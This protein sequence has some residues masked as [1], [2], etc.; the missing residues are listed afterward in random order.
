MERVD[1]EHVR[2]VVYDLSKD[3]DFFREQQ[4][5][6]A[7]T[8]AKV[9]V[10]KSHMAQLTP[11]QV[12]VAER[13]VAA[14]IAKLESGRAL[15]RIWLVVDMDA[16]FAS[17]E[18]RD[19]PH[20][21]K[22][23]MAVG[24]IGMISTAN[25]VARRFGVRSA[26]P[27]F[28]GRKLCPDL[29]F[30]PPSFDKYTAAV[31]ETRAI[32]AR[33]DPDFCSYSLD[34]AYLEITEYCATH[35]CTPEA[36]AQAL[37]DAVRTETR[38]LTCSCGIGPNRM[39]AKVA[40]DRNKPDGQCY[41][42]STREAV[43]AFMAELPC[44]KVPGIGRVAEKTLSALGATTCGE[45]LRLAPQLSL[46]LGPE[47]GLFSGALASALGHGETEKP[48]PLA[49]G[50]AGRRGMSVERTFGD[51]DSEK[52]LE[53]WI[54]QIAT[55]LAEHL[56]AEDLKC[57]SL[58]LKLKTA[59]FE[60]RTR[61]ATLAEPSCTVKQ[62]IPPALRL[63]RAEFPVCCR[64][65]GLRASAFQQRVPPPPGQ[66]MISF[67]AAN[68]ALG[69]P[70]GEADI[71]TCPRCNARTAAGVAAQEHADW[72]VARDLHH[73]MRQEESAWEHQPQHKRPKASDGG[74]KSGGIAALF[75]REER[76]QKG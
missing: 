50:E 34:E 15:S 61:H 22:L 47:S 68:A 31:E 40:S 4:R 55:K 38:G 43:L 56:Q 8:D 7:A 9:A 41:V 54:E 5:R 27:G 20:L 36:V 2:R 66:R 49:P 10:A 45:F 18:E 53:T 67:E 11:S 75:Q 26:M 25:Y 14:R 70:A 12:A 63:L 69:E 35:S 73:S 71:V 51:C 65:L 17:V 3:S 33:F 16:F 62:L 46:V 23:P 1:Q 39:V 19:A 44:R 48:K 21:K 28:I 32:F 24:G 64:L 52:E 74:A 57:R 30:I 76:R 59:A 6:D 37:R 13:A 60:V 58:T 42:P 29:V 72:H